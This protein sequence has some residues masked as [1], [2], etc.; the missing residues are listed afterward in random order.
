M[1]KLLAI[2]VLAI[3]IPTMSYAG[4]G[5]YQIASGGKIE[6]WVL[7]TKTG[8]LRYCTSQGTGTIKAPYCSPS[9]DTSR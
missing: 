9:K 6:V 8:S 3:A 1:K 2:L 7:D 5:R 4:D